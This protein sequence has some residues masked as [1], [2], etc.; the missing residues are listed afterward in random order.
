[1]R[2]TF[3]FIRAMINVFLKTVN[4][5]AFSE[6]GGFYAGA[7]LYDRE[8]ALMVLDLVEAGLPQGLDA[9]TEVQF[10]LARFL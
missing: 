10:W 5:F 3:Y 6:A 8:G 2:I 4:L 1:M 9:D 7:Y